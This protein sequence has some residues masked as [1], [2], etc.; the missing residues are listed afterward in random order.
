MEYI[1]VGEFNYFE[2]SLI[3][4]VLKNNGIEFFIKN[5][6]DS[7]VMA[8][9]AKPSSEFNAITL[10]VDKDKLSLARELLKNK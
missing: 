1:Q 4:T 8:G 10:F 5:S 3:E 6:Y 2:F 7:S 9:W